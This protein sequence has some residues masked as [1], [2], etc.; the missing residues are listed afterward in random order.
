MQESSRERDTCK[1]IAALRAANAELQEQTLAQHTDKCAMEEAST[2]I[3]ETIAALRGAASSANAEQT[4]AQIVQNTE[5]C[6]VQ[7]AMREAA[8]SVSIC[9]FVLVN[10]EKRQVRSRSII[11][12][13]SPGRIS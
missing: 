9:T 6:A 5:K 13:Q 11:L 1:T 10:V 12:A 7:E 3:R 4:L 8:S 2:E